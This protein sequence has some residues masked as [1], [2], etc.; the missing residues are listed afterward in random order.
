MSALESL[1]SALRAQQLVEGPLPAPSPSASPWFVNVLLGLCGWFAAVFMLGFLMLGFMFVT[2]SEVASLLVGTGSIALA[3]LMLTRYHHAFLDNLA[4]ALSLAGQALVVWALMRWFEPMSASVWWLT[5]LLQMVLTVIMPNNIHRV[6]SAY[7]TA[8]SLALG[9]AMLGWGGLFP[10]LALGVVSGLWLNQ[11]TLS[12]KLNTTTMPAWGITLALLT[13]L[14]WQRFSG[15]SSLSMERYQEWVGWA[16]WMTELLCV[17]VMLAVLVAAL[18]RSGVEWHSGRGLLS[19]AVAAVL[20]LCALQAY[21]LSAAMTLVLLGFSQAHRLLMGAGI[22]AM[23]IFVSS[24]YYLLSLT[25]LEK[26]AVLTLVGVVALA[27]RWF[28]VRGLP[29]RQEADHV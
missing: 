14:F 9:L 2:K 12:E 24:Y 26:S 11:L 19:M 7:A 13:A 10:A 28:V 5:G 25:L 16:P 6:F 23:L 3:F 22:L 1:W 29:V 4:L 18:R 17:L 27:L 21:G 15:G 8:I 20:G